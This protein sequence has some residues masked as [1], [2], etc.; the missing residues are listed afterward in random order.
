MEDCLVITVDVSGE[1]RPTLL[2]TRS[3]DTLGFKIVNQLFDDEAVE[4]YNKLV[5]NVK[6][7]CKFCKHCSKQGAYYCMH[8]KHMGDYVPPY[9]VCDD[10]NN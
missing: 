3:S 7:C 4:T 2:V 9:T 8:P 1:D 10:Y 5:G 6:K